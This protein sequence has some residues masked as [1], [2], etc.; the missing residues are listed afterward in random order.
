MFNARRVERIE[1]IAVRGTISRN[2]LS[3]K[4]ISMTKVRKA[5]ALIKKSLHMMT[6]SRQKT[7]G[8]IKCNLRKEGYGNIIRDSFT[9]CNRHQRVFFLVPAQRADFVEKE[10]Q[11][12]VS[13]R[14]WNQPSS[15]DVSTTIFISFT[16]HY[17]PHQREWHW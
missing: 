7:K 13:I 6:V 14:F 3:T 5:S 10:R 17:S 9:M 12:E 2:A 15:F 8:H 1:R 16:L 4:S 11:K